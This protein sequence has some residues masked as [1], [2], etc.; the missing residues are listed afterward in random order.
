[1]RVNAHTRFSIRSGLAKRDDKFLTVID[2]WLW[3]ISWRSLFGPQ[4]VVNNCKVTYLLKESFFVGD[5]G[6]VTFFVW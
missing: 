3:V 2:H 5:Y 1:M 4:F 6:L